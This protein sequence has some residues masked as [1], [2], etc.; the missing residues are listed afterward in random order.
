MY[1]LKYSIRENDFNPRPP[2]EGRLI[3]PQTWAA[4]WTISIHAPR[5][6][7][8]TAAYMATFR[9]DNFNPRPPC[10]GRHAELKATLDDEQISIH[11]P[12]VRG[13]PA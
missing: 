6:R 11:A 9:A 8:D 1:N 12:R 4:T 5:V 13:D 2:C 7:G 3:G 10:E